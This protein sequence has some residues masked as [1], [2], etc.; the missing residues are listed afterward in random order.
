MSQQDA[1]F[2][3]IKIAS[4]LVDKALHD[5]QCYDEL[6]NFFTAPFSRDYFDQNTS[7]FSVKQNIPLPE[8]IYSQ[9]ESLLF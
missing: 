7:L 6:Y 5:E 1:N 8:V 9:Y 3:S 2:E 4:R